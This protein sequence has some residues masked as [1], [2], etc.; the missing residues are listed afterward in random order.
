MYLKEAQAIANEVFY[1]IVPHCKRIE[2]AGSIRRQ[3]AEVNDIDIVLIPNN[4]G[5]LSHVIDRLGIP[6]M[7]GDKLRRFNYKGT[8]VDIYYAT[9]RTWATLLLIRTGSKESNIRLCSA[10]KRK[11]MK[12][13]ANGDGIIDVDGQ[14]IPIDSERQIYDILQLPYKEPWQR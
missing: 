8:Q 6:V 11:G 5:Q 2:V 14:L 4:P 9:P 1:Q 10:A 7:D 13:K 3:K 12:L